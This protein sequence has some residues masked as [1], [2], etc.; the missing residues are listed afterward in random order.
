MKMQNPKPTTKPAT[1]CINQNPKPIKSKSTKLIK[2]RKF[3]DKI[4]RNNKK[5]RS[6][7]KKVT[8]SQQSTQYLSERDSARDSASLTGTTGLLRRL[9]RLAASI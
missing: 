6:R 8:G 3:K 1:L 9:I 4:M 7:R 2:N 5:I